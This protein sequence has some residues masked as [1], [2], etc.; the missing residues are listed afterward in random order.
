VSI[1]MNVRITIGFYYNIMLLIIMLLLGSCSHNKKAEVISDNP[2]EIHSAIS[3]FNTSFKYIS[4]ISIENNADYKLLTIKGASRDLTYLLYPKGSKADTAWPNTSF[5][6]AVP[7]QN[8]TSL[9]ASSIGYLNDLNCLNKIK[10]ISK[11]QYVYNTFIRQKIDEG[12]LI[13]LGEMQQLDYEKLL[14]TKSDLFIQ[15]NYSNDF[16]IDQRISKAGITTLLMSDWKETN[17]LGRAEWIKVIALFVQK[18]IEAD[19][20]FNVIE[21]RYLA[22]KDTAA[23]FDEQKTALLGA[24]FKDV[25]YMPAGESYKARLLKDAAV[26]YKWKN[27]EGTASLPLSLEVVIKNQANA[28]VWIECPF[29][30]YKELISQDSRFGIFTA[31]KNK[32]IYQYKKQ[33]HT[34]GANNYWERGVGR[35]DELLSDLINVFHSDKYKTEMFYYEKLK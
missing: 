11:K 23:K 6:I 20:I 15:S 22:L 32:K 5:K 28:G 30:T 17:P 31:F 2:Q 25:W 12:S 21:K 27:E 19:S 13:E 29:R 3:N 14:S 4:N 24:P 16:E 34:D 35:P 7:V 26:N 8:I 1:A 9:V 10:A 33:L 18:E